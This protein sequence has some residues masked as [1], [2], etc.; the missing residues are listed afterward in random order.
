M[1]LSLCAL[2]VAGGCT[3]GRG[4]PAE[5]RGP[6]TARTRR[7]AG[8]GLGPGPP[9]AAR[10]RRSATAGRRSAGP[11]S[12]RSRCAGTRARARRGR[13]QGGARQ[14]G[15]ACALVERLARHGFAVAPAFPLGVRR[16]E[17]DEEAAVG[18]HR[19][20]ARHRDTVPQTEVRVHLP[21]PQGGTGESVATVVQGEAVGAGVEVRVGTELFVGADTDE[22]EVGMGRL[23][24][25][26]QVPG[27]AGAGE[28]V[29]E[30]R[31][32]GRLRDPGA[33]LGVDEV[34]EE[35]Q[36]PR[37]LLGAHDIR[38]LGE[39]L[40]Q[41]C[42]VRAHFGQRDTVPEGEAAV[43]PTD[44]DP[45]KVAHIGVLVAVE[46]HVPPDRG[47]LLHRFDRGR[48]RCHLDSF[49]RRAFRTP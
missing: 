19:G 14:S 5:G 45:R 25:R 23:G 10:V 31:P 6:D 22:R 13:V 8:T 24:D 28:G 41:Q 20:G 37:V 15:G 36:E 16:D 34:L 48:E 11:S 4:G 38:R 29:G 43:G 12:V 44:R 7:R 46:H 27:H 35:P 30:T 9:R 32:F 26:Q 40:L 1:C 18:F 2:H 33:G 17:D 39:A 42:R 21:L 47:E 3:P 49:D